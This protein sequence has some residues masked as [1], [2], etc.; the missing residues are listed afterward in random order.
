MSLSGFILR[1]Q[2]ILAISRHF[3]LQIFPKANPST[4]VL[5]ASRSHRVTRMNAVKQYKESNT[6][7]IQITVI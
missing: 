6:K 3:T 5:K 2:M 7:N 1:M 4:V